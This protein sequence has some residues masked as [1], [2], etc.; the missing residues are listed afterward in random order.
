MM[1]LHF[2]GIEPMF[3]S[4]TTLDDAVERNECDT[5]CRLLDLVLSF[6]IIS[7]WLWDLFEKSGTK[8]LL[9]TQIGPQNRAHVFLT[10]QTIPEALNDVQ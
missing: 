7:K 10:T 6:V 3:L 9:W 2:P 4:F 5:H 1:H 8:N